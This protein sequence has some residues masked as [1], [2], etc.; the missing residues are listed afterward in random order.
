[1][2][3]RGRE[4][5]LLALLLLHPNEPLA[6][7]RIIDS[8]WSD[9]APAQAAKS[10]Q[11]YVSRLRRVLGADRIATTAAGYAVIVKAG[12]RDID[13]FEELGREGRG[14]FDRGDLTGAERRLSEALALWRGDALSDFRYEEFA[15]SAVSHLE[16]LRRNAEADRIDGRI[17][18]GRADEVIARLE[19]LIAAAPL[20]ERPRE[21][22][23]LA[24]YRSG[25]QAEALDLYRNTRQLFDAELGI[26]PGEHLQQLERRILNQDPSLG[27]VRR[28][29]IRQ[30]RARSAWLFVG[31]GAVFVAVAAG[32]VALLVTRGSAVALAA[33]APNSLAQIDAKSGKLVAQVPVG[34]APTA[35]AADGEHVW[36]ADGASQ[37]LLEIDSRAH[38][39]RS[40]TH[41]PTI[42]TEAVS[43][44]EAVWLTGPLD[45][46]GGV[47]MRVDVAT[48]AVRVIRVHGPFVAD[49]FAPA[50]PNALAIAGEEVWTDTVHGDLVRVV[51]QHARNLR[52]KRQHS[53]DGLAYG[54]G[55]IWVTSSVDDSVLRLDAES[56]KLAAAPIRIASIPGRRAASP[57]GVAYGEG[58]VWVADALTDRLTRIDP[59][60]NSVSE[61]IPVGRRPTAVAVGAGAVWVVNAG[62]G[63]VSKIDPSRGEVVRT[64]P[65][66]HSLTSIAAAEHDVWVSVAGGAAAP[67]PAPPRP[68]TAVRSASCGPVQSGD[69]A[70]DLLVVS[71]LPKHDNDKR[72]NLPIVDMEHAILATLASHDF[73]AGAYRIGYQACTDSAPGAS[74]D[75]PRCAANARAYAANANVVGMI[76]T[77]QSNCAKVELPILNSA[78]TGPVAVISPSNTYVGLTHPGPQTEADEPDRYYPTGIRNYVRL[79]PADDAQAAGLVRFA[80]QQG[81]RRLFLLDDGDATGV[82][83]VAYVQ[84]AARRLGVRVVGSAHWGRG[85]YVVLG[86]RVRATRPDAVVLTGC[87][88][89]NGGGIL[90]DLGRALGPRVPFLATDNFTFGGNMAGQDAPPAA[91]RTYITQTRAASA[92][93]PANGRAFLRTTFP[94]RPLADIA[95]DVPAAAAAMDLLLTAIA[96]SDGSRSSVVDQLVRGRAVGSVIGA[97][98]FDVDGDPADAPVTI[99]RISRDAPFT[100]HVAVGGLRLVRVVIGDPGLAAP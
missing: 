17:A 99:A 38:R 25:R 43:T 19:A 11:V 85:P 12:E 79:A 33:A 78:P 90:T 51:R 61:T 16:E 84:Q 6:T 1:M 46:S 2:I 56:G 45:A 23:M 71:D 89:N 81:L 48:R 82:A 54:D 80:K 26:E 39:I 64:I 30:L 70:P 31:A 15:Q 63:T 98:T 36:V 68:A 62:D 76:G 92:A 66:G 95:L 49:L 35:V 24:L 97:V 75:L 67:S 37:E 4:S 74:P 83:M 55:S 9:N 29:P 32:I 34:S 41:L 13:R 96:R 93:L 88:C 47:L 58:S 10:V 5:A 91:F 40:R 18:Q 42:P 8:L 53:V 52:I 69:R 50:V 77:Y 94:D 14:A 87:I 22:L 57:G 20:W 3:G 28:E 21:Q 65:V 100:P 73:R 59:K 7:D 27:R 72:V 44:P 60:T 86:R